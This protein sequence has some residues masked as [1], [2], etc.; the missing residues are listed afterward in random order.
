MRL[1][2]ILPI[3]PSD[4]FELLDYLRGDGKMISEAYALF[5]DI[6]LSSN[7]YVTTPRTLYGKDLGY[8]IKDVEITISLLKSTGFTDNE[9]IIILLNESL[10]YL[11]NRR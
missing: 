6:K 8:V 2:E 7:E 10:S 9:Q 11:S 3:E 5:N 4:K 1:D